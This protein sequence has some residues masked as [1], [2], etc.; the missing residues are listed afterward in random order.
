MAANTPDKINYHYN[1]EFNP[2]ETYDPDDASKAI[3]D[4]PS[5]KQP[6]YGNND[7]TGL[8]AS[9][10][11]HVA[12]IIAARRGNG[13][14]DES[15]ALITDG[16]AP[17]ARIMSVR[18]VPDGDERD[19]DIAN[20]V[21]YAV[22]NGARIINMSFGKV[23]S[24]EKKQVAKAF[25]YAASKGVLMV[26]AAGNSSFDIGDNGHFPCRFEMSD[27]VKKHWIE[28]GSTT[29]SFKR[30]EYVSSFSNFGNQEGKAKIDVFAPGSA[31][32]STIPGGGVASFNGTSMATPHVAGIAALVLSHAPEM[33]GAEVKE[34]LLDNVQDYSDKT[35]LSPDEH[36]V[37]FGSLSI[38]G[39]EVS[40]IKSL[41]ALYNE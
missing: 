4:Y 22:D 38:T 18:V 28:V 39:G 2:L 10:G 11:T 40:A 7:V 9:H 33:T 13:R 16:I 5:F 6:F 34:L 3:R 36:Y 19:E 8:D 37:D 26:H 25:E 35:V 24:P 1:L 41:D 30:D 29:K 17:Q 20:A 23:F 12:G 27:M 15:G 21:R 31:I 14:K 32:V